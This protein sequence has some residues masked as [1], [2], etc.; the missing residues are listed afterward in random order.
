MGKKKKTGEISA[1]RTRF[2]FCSNDFCC[3]WCGTPNPDHGDTC[4]N[5]G[6]NPYEHK[7]INLLDFNPDD[8]I[9]FNS[10]IL[11]RK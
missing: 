8:L 10:E 2:H 7:Q 9:L 1:E 5:C 3:R 6:N 11:Y 4:G